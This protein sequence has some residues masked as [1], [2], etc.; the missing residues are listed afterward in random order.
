MT[1]G[2]LPVKLPGMLAALILALAAAATPAWAQDA[3]IPRSYAERTSDRARPG[4][5]AEEIARETAT[6][7]AAEAA[8]N[9]VQMA[10]CS[11][12]G[13]AYHRGEGRPQNRPVAELV[14]RKAC[15]AAEASACYRLGRLLDSVNNDDDE[16]RAADEYEAA[17]MIARGCRLGSL[18]ACDAEAD[19]LAAGTLGEADPA[20]AEALR[21]RN[22]EAGW[23]ASCR[24]LAD[25]LFGSDRSDADKAEGRALLDRLCRAGDRYA[26]N[27][28]ERHWTGIE[29][30]HG[31]T[32]LAYEALA[33]DAGDGWGCARMAKAALRRAP[34]DRAAAL[35]LF[36]R[37][38]AAESGTCADAANLR[39]E[40]LLTSRCD[41]ADLAA[42]RRLGEL[43]AEQNGP[44]E[45][46]PRALELLGAVC[47]AEA[48]PV[49]TT[50]AS[51]VFDAW[52]DTGMG[53]P[54]RAEYYLV[55]GCES[56]SADACHLL[57]DSLADGA[58]LAQDVSRAAELYADQCDAGR[59][60]ACRFVMQLS[61]TDPSAPLLLATDYL[62]PDQTPEEIAAAQQAER[63]AEERERAEQRARR[64]T[65]TVVV[66]EGVAYSDTLC[67]NVTRVVN[68]FTVPR[69]EQAPWQAMLWRPPVVNGKKVPLH[70]RVL[71]GGTLIRTGWILTA[72]HC[73]TD[74]GGI[75]LDKG[76]HQVRLGVIQP[77][78]EE[79]TSYKI[80]RV[81]PHKDYRRN[82]MQFDI[83]LVQYDPRSGTRGE[84]L[85]VAR[86]INLDRRTLAERPVRAQAP[87]FV[88]GWGRTA[89]GGKKTPD[90]LQGARLLLQDANDCTELTKF[91]D[92]RKDSILCAA[93]AKREQA[94]TGDSGGPLITYGDKKGVPTLIGVV[95]SG[96]DCGTR[97]IAS[98]FV[99]IGH[100][101]VQEWLAQNLPG[102]R[103]GRSG[104]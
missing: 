85:Y 94:C 87:V 80:L 81:I 56:G 78:S 24:T 27:D 37:A 92:E 100:P 104:P 58:L 25:L 70:D 97:G 53:Q 51:L 57:A 59:S 41:N 12:L 101:K 99:R 76:G 64:C 67:D 23:Q 48:S 36:D 39:E 8:C 21:R 10:G 89:F 30:I 54:E 2:K 31:A 82:T 45:N 68:G 33:C 74:E 14:Y 26:C 96:V 86:H 47:E 91:R 60:S 29:G 61:E 102:F 71:C 9:A 11:D 6:A 73:V 38:C 63:E 98:R 18:E 83:A 103:H 16:R 79:G 66:Y 43:M 65:T 17:V 34:S 5:P 20:A 22:C 84:N 4:K 50:A 15:A 95:S 90:F 1:M 3:P 77:L 42:C 62:P 69:I 75:T 40:P 52:R 13:W 46:R 7:D 28:A 88:F 19:D 72:A 35:A 49:C 32:V 44:L 55:R 93:G